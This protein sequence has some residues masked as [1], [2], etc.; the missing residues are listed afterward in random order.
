MRVIH[1]PENRFDVVRGLGDRDLVVLVGAEPHLYW[2][3]YAGCI[4]TVVEALGCEAVVSVGSSAE[5]V[6]H[7][8]VPLVTGSTTDAELA[9]RLGIGLPTY[10]GVTGVAGVRAR[11]PRRRRHARRCHLRVGVPHYLMNAEHPQAV[12][13]LQAHLTHVLNVPVPTDDGDARDRHRPL[14]IAARRGRRRRSAT[15]DVRAHARDRARPPLRS[16]DPVRRRP[17]CRVRAI[18]TRT[19]RRL[20]DAGNYLDAGRTAARRASVEAKRR[21]RA[22]EAEGPTRRR[23]SRVRGRR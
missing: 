16:I 23:R 2:R 15:A 6:P 7:T 20:K 5:A 4:R 22:R 14:A 13:A 18:P 1:W 12:A 8:R 10:E 3:T 17:G 9:R 19:P 11:R 21:R